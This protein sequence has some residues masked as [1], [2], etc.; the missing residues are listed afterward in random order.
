MDETDITMLWVLIV[1]LCIIGFLLIVALFFFIFPIFA[2]KWL[3]DF[4]DGVSGSSYSSS[5]GGGYSSST[6]E[7]TSSWDR[8]N[9]NSMQ[10]F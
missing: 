4:D 6:S 8:N 10:N 2:P 3:S 5:G 9:I 1:I 7:D